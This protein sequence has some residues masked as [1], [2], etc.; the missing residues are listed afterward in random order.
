MLAIPRP[1]RGAA[2]ILTAAFLLGPFPQARGDEPVAA[3]PRGVADPE[4]KV[5]AVSSFRHTVSGLDLHTGKSVWETAVD[6]VPLAFVDRLVLVLA[7]DGRKPNTATVIAVDP[8]TGR[9]IW[10]SDPMILPEWAVVAP[11]DNHYFGHLVRIK[12]GNLWLKWLALSR[13]AGGNKP[14]H[15]AA[16]VAR[17]DL[18]SHK[19]EMLDADQMPPPELPAGVSK[20][21]AKLAARPA[22]TPAGPET[23]VV[24]A[25]DLAVALDVE[26][27]S[28][29]LRRW[30][31]K[32]EKALDPV[33]LAQGGRFHATPFPA[34]G[35]VLIRPAGKDAP[36]AA[37]WQV[38][39]LETGKRIAR[40]AAER[41]A[42]QPTILGSR[43]YYA[44]LGKLDIG[45]PRAP[46]LP[47][48][49]Q[50]RAVDLQTAG[51]LWTCPLENLPWDPFSVEVG[52]VP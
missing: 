9:L 47:V 15:T 49:R 25:G 13:K 1:S 30:D 22:E 7:P 46:N 28:V 34:S 41:D 48:V 24:T 42:L 35:A 31:L 23:R 51:K 11:A 12:E 45:N 52:E 18:K 44:F 21:L 19:V 5:G 4:L 6:G 26:K 50:L 39:S 2:F 37:V 10:R 14:D 38:F 29:T 20:A 16:G 36:G 43:L 33:V 32:T 40:L 8:A 3:L 27:G 17:L